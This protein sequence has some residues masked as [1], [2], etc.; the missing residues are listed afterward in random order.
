MERLNRLLIFDLKGQLGHFRKFYTTS[1][2][3]T[4]TFPPRTVVTGL[5]AGI[6]GRERDTYYEEFSIGNCKVGISI[7]TAVRKIMQSVNYTRTKKEDGFSSLEGVIRSFIGRKITSYPTPIELVMS[8][9]DSREISYRIYFYHQDDNLM[10]EICERVIQGR[11][12]YPPYLGL[13]EFLGKVEF[14]A[15]V[16]EEHMKVFHAHQFGKIATVCNFHMIEELE[17]EDENNTFQYIEEKMPLEFAPGREIRQKASF[18][19]EQKG[20]PIIAKLNR[21][22]LEIDYE[23]PSPVKDFVTFLE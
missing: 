3:L 13:S 16:N 4:Y 23:D 9:D 7:R 18:L 20:L 21:S 5:I 10:E 15:F 19:H 1:S 12:A 17:F 14:I 6:L 22:C 8:A 2:S 11:F